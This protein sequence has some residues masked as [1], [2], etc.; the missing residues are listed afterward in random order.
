VRNRI[1][2]ESHQNI[3]TDAKI[4]Y[5]QDDGSEVDISRCVTGVDVRLHVGEAS[6]ATLNVILVDVDAQAELNDVVIKHLKPH[7]RSWWWR[8]NLSGKLKSW[9]ARAMSQEL[10]KEIV[11]EGRRERGLSA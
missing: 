1:R 7:R 10:R 8:W 6:T 9:L 2:I 4:F 5:V 11:R 3:V